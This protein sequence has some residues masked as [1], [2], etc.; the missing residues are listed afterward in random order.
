[1]GS[2]DLFNSVL[3]HGLLR[4]PM[5]SLRS[6][7]ASLPQSLTYF[8]S[9]LLHI[10]ALHFN[11]SSP[12]LGFDSLTMSTDLICGSSLSFFVTSPVAMLFGGT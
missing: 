5:F 7:H 10:V 12:V 2:S 9:L 11:Q 6:H 4:C 8:N 1:M 3:L